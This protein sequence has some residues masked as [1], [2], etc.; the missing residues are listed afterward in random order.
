[1][2]KR[3][4]IEVLQELVSLGRATSSFVGMQRAAALCAELLEVEL[5]AILHLRSKPPRL[6]L[7]AL[8]PCAAETVGEVRKQALKWS[9]AKELDEQVQQSFGGVAVGEPSQ[10]L[11]PADHA[12]TPLGT[13]ASCGLL[14]AYSGTA[15]HFDKGRLRLL[16][17]AAQICA[18][19]IPSDTPAPGKVDHSLLETAL[20][21][22][23]DGLL[24]TERSREDVLL[25]PAAREMLGIDGDARV[26]QRYLKE[27]LDFYPFD[28]VSGQGGDTEILREELKFGERRLHSMISPVKDGGD[29]TGV[30]VVLR[31]FTEAHALAH[32]QQEFLASNSHELRT[33]LT[34]ITG[35]LD[36]ALGEYA[37]ALNDNLRRYLN[38]ARKSCTELNGSIDGLI[39]AARHNT[40]E[41]VLHFGEVDLSDL[42][43]SVA[44][45]HRFSAAEKNTR[46]EIK[47]TDEILLIGGDRKRLTQVLDNLLSNAIKFA[48]TDGL[49][50]VE[51]F[52]RSVSDSHAG[53]SVFNNGAPIDEAMREAIFENFEGNRRAERRLSGSG[54]GLAVSR[55]IVEA[56]GGRVWAESRREGAKFIF[57]LPSGP[58]DPES[59]EHAV[60]ELAKPQP[61]A[62]SSGSSVVLI[63]PD[64]QSSYILKGLL[65]ASDHQV[66]VAEDPDAGLMECRKR[67]PSLVVIHGDEIDDPL[68]LAEILHHDPD[69]RRSAILVLTA[70]GAVL[71]STSAE[72]LSLPIVPEDFNEVCT[73][74][75]SEAAG[76]HSGRVL[77]V[78]DEA[79]IR[80][81]CSGVLRHAGLSV[82]EASS[83][84]EAIAEAKRFRPD[85]VLLD[86]H[87][88]GLRRLPHCGTAQ[89]RSQY[90]ND[91]H[92]LP[93]RLGR[94]KRQGPRLP[95]WCRRLHGEA[96]CRGGARCPGS[97][98]SGTEQS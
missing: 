31:D 80:S 81:I 3:D 43:G 60:I 8:V 71:K 79:A 10:Y 92:H 62:S 58:R 27:R 68:A 30:V 44:A 5:C 73:R 82:R 40:G 86:I 49:I 21:S 93:L 50:E 84:L 36:I 56:H 53:V 12:H 16:M 83:G 28:L 74:L 26:T 42:A 1:M 20:N 63:S 38:L 22:M 17:L 6:H 55:A 72:L 89:E 34:S 77:I 90:G 51:V 33:P 32:R 61:P 59:G 4:S 75:I 94:D 97:Q 39:D 88:A 48:P 24:M 85:L 54:L 91:P 69:T 7:H 46:I 13:D 23:A 67:R 87:D 37:E 70:Q 25:N 11:A 18:Q 47:G 57:T 15:D 64:H 9:G 52:G 66:F 35:A 41:M 14:L 29:T 19:T 2:A 78:D 45:R 76:Q 98:S 95:A 65:M 96:I